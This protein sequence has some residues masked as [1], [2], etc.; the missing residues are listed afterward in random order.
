MSHLS[1]LKPSYTRDDCGYFLLWLSLFQSAVNWSC[2]TY[3]K[4]LRASLW[5]KSLFYMRSCRTS[6]QG[7]HLFKRMILPLQCDIRSA[8]LKW[9]LTHT[10]WE[11]TICY[12]I[13]LFLLSMSSYWSFDLPIL[14]TSLGDIL[15]KGSQ[16]IC[17][18]ATVANPDELAGW[19]D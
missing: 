16:L 4:Y 8:L 15:S 11:E 6:R 17:L 18:S 13:T 10:V 2:I 3:L 12:F 14:T 9:Y 1:N 7:T 19:I 5:L